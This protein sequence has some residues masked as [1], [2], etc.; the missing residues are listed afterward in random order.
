MSEG[1]DADEAT[2]ALIAQ[3]LAEDEA[4]YGRYQPMMHGGMEDSYAASDH[5]GD[6]YKE[7]EEGGEEEEEE[8]RRYPRKPARRGRKKKKIIEEQNDSTSITGRKKRRDAGQARGAP[9]KKWSDEEHALFLKGLDCCGRDWKEISNLMEGRRDARAVSSHAQKHFLRLYREKIPL[10]AKVLESGSGYTIS[11]EPLDEESSAYKRYASRRPQGVTITNF[12]VLDSS[13]PI[14]SKKEECDGP[15]S[16]KGDSGD[17]IGIDHVIEGKNVIGHGESEQDSGNACEDPGVKP[18]QDKPKKRG[19]KRKVQIVDEKCV[20]TKQER[21]DYASSRLRPKRKKRKSVLFSPFVQ[22]GDESLSLLPCFPYENGWTDIQHRPS[23]MRDMQPFR[24]EV[25]YRAMVLMD[26]HVHLAS[27][28]VIGLLGGTW[29]KE[30]SLIRIIEAFPCRSIPSVQEEVSVELDPT[31]EVDVRGRIAEKSL[32]VVG[33]YHSHPFFPP[34][35]SFRDIANQLNYQQLLEDEKTGD[36]PFVGAIFCPYGRDIPT[37]HSLVSWFHVERLTSAD[38][39]KKLRIQFTKKLENDLS[40]LKETFESLSKEYSEFP[41][42][43]NWDE[44]WRL[45]L[46]APEKASHQSG[47]KGEVSTVHKSLKSEMG[48]EDADGIEIDISREEDGDGEEREL[49][50]DKEGEKMENDEKPPDMSESSKR[51]LPRQEAK[52]Y[53]DKV[54]SALN[55]WFRGFVEERERREFVD[56]VLRF[57]RREWK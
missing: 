35:P 17:H 9:P 11:G 44:I 53:F 22:D 1:E 38:Q 16:Q 57:I 32:H 20:P 49:M 31:S 8:Y 12:A 7:G 36:Q 54:A 45:Q 14:F 19:R 25:E 23:S 55:E 18:T 47:S 40:L 24:I 52:S 21:S 2:S 33:W 37:E 51:H 10:P 29:D 41:T 6:E 15:K 39:P 13:S 46:I 48:T 3:L 34:E 28:E 42:R 50:T 30:R 43:V 5:D 26:F 4:S 56:S 27:T